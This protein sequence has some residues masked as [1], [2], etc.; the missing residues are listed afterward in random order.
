MPT[1]TLIAIYLT[2]SG[3]HWNF[4]VMFGG[5]WWYHSVIWY[6]Y[7]VQSAKLRKWK[8]DMCK[9]WK[10]AKKIYTCIQT[11]AKNR[12]VD[13]VWNANEDVNQPVTNANFVSTTKWFHIFTLH[14][15]HVVD[16]ILPHFIQIPWHVAHIFLKN[17]FCWAYRRTT[18]M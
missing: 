8:T 16:F 3:V 18:R 6:M 17:L 13:S 1:L 9:M 5:H 12:I 11:V 15:F 2:I 10:N 4:P 7:K 14:T